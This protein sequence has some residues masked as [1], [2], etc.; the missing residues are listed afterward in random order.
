MQHFTFI[1]IL[2]WGALEYFKWIF[3]LPAAILYYRMEGFRKFGLLLGALFLILLGS[4][5]ENTLAPK[6]DAE[7]EAIQ[8]ASEERLGDMLQE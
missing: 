8:N 3:I 1:F 7:G 5:L 4:E 6:T 2:I